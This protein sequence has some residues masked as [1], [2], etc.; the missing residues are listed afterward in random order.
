MKKIFLFF[1]LIIVLTEL[2]SSVQL[3]ISPSEIEFKGEVNEKICRDATIYSDYSGSLNGEI[4]WMKEGQTGRDLKEYNFGEKALGIESE[5]PTSIFVDSEKKI[6]VCLMFQEPGQYSGALIYSTENSNV[7]VGSWIRVNI[8]GN[9]IEPRVEEITGESIALVQKKVEN[10][11][12]FNLIFFV[13][14]VML[15]LMFTLL[16][17]INKRVKK[18][19]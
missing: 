5:Y 6:K 10:K 4:R 13:I 8:N 18:S 2:I 12:S 17:F 16:L 11:T 7:G 15:A 1:V 9:R 3:G 14:F 19:Y